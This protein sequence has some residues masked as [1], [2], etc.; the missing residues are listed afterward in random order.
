MPINEQF[1]VPTST[2]DLNDEKR[3]NGR[4][5]LFIYQE[6]EAIQEIDRDTVPDRECMTDSGDYT[7][8]RTI[9]PIAIESGV[10]PG[11][12]TSIE[13]YWQEVSVQDSDK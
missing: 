6:R 13:V 10:Q 5:C 3:G 11:S 8:P 4:R 1:G 2:K 12:R 7:I 9:G